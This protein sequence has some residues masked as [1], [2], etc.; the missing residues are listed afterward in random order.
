M[1]TKTRFL[2]LGLAICAQLALSRPASAFQFWSNQNGTASFFD[3][4]NGGSDNGLFGDPTLVGGDTFVFFPQGWRAESINGVPSIKADRLQVTLTAHAGQSFTGIIIHE[5]GD[6]GI[7][8][9][10]SVMASGAAFA[11]DLQQF[12]VA[13]DT[14]DTTPV[15]PVSVTNSATAGVWSGDVFID[16]TDPEVPWEEL[17]LVFDNNLLAISGVG[18]LSFIEKKVIGITLVPEP[19]ALALLGLGTLAFFARRRRS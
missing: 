1:L 2:I 13:N 16:L 9:T 17:T 12:R 18:S 5:E 10:G 11:T 6:Y 7:L 3:W 14:M 4:S 19:T 15:F 8:G